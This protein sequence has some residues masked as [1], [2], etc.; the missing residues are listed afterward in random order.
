[1][2]FLKDNLSVVF[3]ERISCAGECDTDVGV[4]LGVSIWLDGGYMGGGDNW[5]CDHIRVQLTDGQF[6][7]CGIME[8]IH[9][10][11]KPRTCF[12]LL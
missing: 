6:A 2:S 7:R 10:P 11:H 1:M 8:W 5:Y 4:V 3:C 9:K 12:F